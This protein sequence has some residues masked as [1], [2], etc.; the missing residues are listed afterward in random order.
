MMTVTP[1]IRHRI[2]VLVNEV[3]RLPALSE[4]PSVQW[5]LCK[6]IGQSVFAFY[7]NETMV[8]RIDLDSPKMDLQHLAGLI[9][10]GANDAFEAVKSKWESS[11][12]SL[13]LAIRRVSKCDNSSICGEALQC[14]AGELTLQRRHSGRTALEL[15]TYR[16]EFD[17][18]QTS[19][20]RLE[21]YIEKHFLQKTSEIFEY[22]VE[23]LS[24]AQ[25][26][27][28]VSLGPGNA[29]RGES[30]TQYLPVDSIGFSSVLLHLN[31]IPE[32][33]TEALRL[34]LAAAETGAVL[35]VWSAAPEAAS[36]GWN[37]FSL[38]RALDE[39][40]LTLTITVECPSP[41]SGWAMTL[42]PPL[43]Y[44]EFCAQTSG[45]SYLR[46]PL[47][48]R[49]RAG[50]PGVRVSRTIGTF[51]PEKASQARSEFVP[52]E[53]LASS[54][55]ALPEAQEGATA[56]VLSDPEI[57][58]ITVHPC[59]DCATV[60][61]L[62]VEVPTEAWA[63]SVQIHLAHAEASW[64]QF[65][66]AICA[67]DEVGQ[68]LSR[69][70]EQDAALPNS[71]G[72]RGLAALESGR[73]LV[74]IEKSE[75]RRRAVLLATRQASNASPDFAWARFSSIEFHLLPDFFHSGDPS[76]LLSPEESVDEPDASQ[77]GESDAAQINAEAAW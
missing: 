39:D 12:P 3:D 9:V 18:L 2:A 67:P 65:A 32:P 7:Q 44:P 33:G 17:R 63:I 45:G 8:G 61:R 62:D 1:E 35:G 48:L 20:A 29:A 26:S 64:T 56:L 4:V 47:G 58:C 59:K 70:S 74:A 23:T 49:I 21:Q 57:C 30:L 13:G 36:T 69:L 37:E 73:L 15:A 27:N 19:F 31:A 46:A 10:V 77:G 55:Q 71:S 16:R 68:T 28:S 50:L 52:F 22:P 51:Y 11:L 53:L 34:T 14:I 76:D 75:D 66:M 43:P 25:E 42:G 41:D 38:D 72:W 6:Q 60:A 24:P 54:I 40:A 5:L